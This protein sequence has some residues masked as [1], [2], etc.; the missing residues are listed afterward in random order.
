MAV[1]LEETLCYD[2]EKREKFPPQQKGRGRENESALSTPLRTG[3][4]PSLTCSME[5]FPKDRGDIE[6]DIVTWLAEFVV[7]GC[8]EGNQGDPSTLAMPTQ[9]DALAIGSTEICDTTRS[10]WLRKHFL[11]ECFLAILPV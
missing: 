3:W 6:W 2:P 11:R 4:N 7:D 8:E 5:L 1:L 10:I 9:E